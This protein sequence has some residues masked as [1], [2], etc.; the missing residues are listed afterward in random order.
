MF[1]G[2]D[3]PAAEAVAALGEA[4]L[5]DLIGSAAR[6]EAAAMARRLMAVAELFERRAAQA[7]DRELWLLDGHEE[8]NAE[9]AAALGISRGRAAG[10]V[11]VAVALRER[12]PRVL[13]TFAEGRISYRVVSEIV[14]RTQLVVSDEDMVELD[15]L[16]AQRAHRWDRLSDR[17]LTD[18]VDRLAMEFDVLAKKPRR[19]C[20][21][22]REIGMAPNSRGTVDLWG[23]LRPTDAAAFESRLNQLADSVCSADPRTRAQRRADATGPLAVYA[24][25]MECLCGRPDCPAGSA[26]GVA[27]RPEVVVTVLTDGDGRPAYVPGLGFFDRQSIEPALEQAKR[28]VVR[29]PGEGAVAE[30]GYRPSKG[31][32][33]FIRWRDL[34][35]RF[36]GCSAPARVCDIDH[37][38]PWPA[39]PTHPSNLKLLCRWHHL[40]KTFW[41][42]WWGDRQLGDGTVIWT[43]PTGHTYTTKP[44]GALFFPVLD[45]PTGKLV[46]PQN[47][48]P[49]SQGRAEFMPKRRRTRREELEAR[50]AYERGLNAKILAAQ[51]PPPDEDPPPF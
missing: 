37:T 39:G 45:R 23:T 42:D 35:C 34:T 20:D 4:G 50:V 12:L 17:K 32:A 27:A 10:L 6:L 2:V 41:G 47:L 16:V 8:L 15:R 7:E 44:D 49:P 30:A 29:H 48:P 46:L 9:V 5:V 14:S 24:D 13:A 1:D 22:D 26:D 28:R 38:V 43:S 36:P 33:E 40:L 3:L 18:A 19:D 11:R 51:P 31:L 21:E 25:R